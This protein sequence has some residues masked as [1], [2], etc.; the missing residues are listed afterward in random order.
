MRHRDTRKWNVLERSLENENVPRWNEILV[1]ILCLGEF[2]ANATGT[3]W[4][5]KCLINRF[6]PGSALMLHHLRRKLVNIS[7]KLLLRRNFS[8]RTTSADSRNIKR[9]TR[10]MSNE[11]SFLLVGQHGCDLGNQ[12]VRRARK[13]VI[14]HNSSCGFEWRL[15]DYSLS[16]SAIPLLPTLNQVSSQNIFHNAV[17]FF[18]QNSRLRQQD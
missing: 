2:D 7:I 6:A 18:D 10:K 5:L 15:P 1:S 4:L 11:T 9:G 8:K 14:L 17:W 3:S 13:A 16:F 12:L